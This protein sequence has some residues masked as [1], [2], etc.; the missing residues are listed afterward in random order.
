MKW[1]GFGR[2]ENMGAWNF[3]AILL[4]D[5]LMDHQKLYCVNP[6]ASASHCRRFIKYNSMK[7]NEVLRKALAKDLKPVFD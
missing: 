6:D 1:C 4:N 3:L 2:A 7:H 5:D